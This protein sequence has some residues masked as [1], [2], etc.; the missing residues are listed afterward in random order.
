MPCRSGHAALLRL[1]T[2]E[3]ERLGECCVFTPL[4]SVPNKFGVGYWRWLHGVKASGRHVG[5]SPDVRSLSTHAP[6]RGEGV[7]LFLFLF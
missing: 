4:T 3:N 5:R 2:G 1:L 7:S 6:Q